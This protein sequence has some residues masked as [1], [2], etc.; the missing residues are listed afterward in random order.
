MQTSDLSEVLIPLERRVACGFVR[1]GIT[2]RVKSDH[3][4]IP[5]KELGLGLGLETRR[6]SAFST[7]TYRILLAVAATDTTSIYTMILRGKQTDYTILNIET[8]VVPTG[9]YLAAT[10]RRVQKASRQVIQLP[11]ELGPFLEL[12]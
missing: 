2:F 12:Q 8:P 1:Y 3:Y 10:S 11:E 6:G 7:P 9:E 4:L 5:T